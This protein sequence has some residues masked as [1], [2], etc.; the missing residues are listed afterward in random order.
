MDSKDKL[1]EAEIE[2][3]LATKVAEDMKEVAE[4]YQG[5][6]GQMENSS[7]PHCSTRERLPESKAEQKARSPAAASISSRQRRRRQLRRRRWQ[8]R[9]RRQLR[10]LRR[11]RQRRQRRQRTY[12]IYFWLGFGREGRHVAASAPQ[13]SKARRVL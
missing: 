2:A 5:K 8:Q 7:S 1:H 4:I 9:Q 10:Q 13:R 3:S 11:R 6:L 12:L